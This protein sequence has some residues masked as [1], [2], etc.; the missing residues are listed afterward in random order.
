[1]KN[2]SIKSSSDNLYLS[3]IIVG[4]LQDNIKTMEAAYKFANMLSEG[5]VKDDIPTLVINI[6]E[7]ETVKLFAN[8]Y[9]SVR[10]SYFNEIDSYAKSKGLN[11]AQIVEGIC[12][13]PWIG[14]GYNNPSFGYGGA[15]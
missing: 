4:A 15:A 14:K 6:T 7:A 8:T 10:V 13:D 2:K 9:L 12:L 5:T 3:R 11:T 1:M